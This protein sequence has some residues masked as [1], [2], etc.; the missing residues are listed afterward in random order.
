MVIEKKNAVALPKTRSFKMFPMK[1]MHVCFKGSI[2]PKHVISPAGNREIPFPK[3][4]LE[5]PGGSGG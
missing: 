1:K 4:V 2:L 3:Q 5:G